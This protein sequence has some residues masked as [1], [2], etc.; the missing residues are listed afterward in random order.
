LYKANKENN[1]A[2][3]LYA[4]LTMICAL[5]GGIV[6]ISCLM[7]KGDHWTG[8]NKALLRYILVCCLTVSFL[9][10]AAKLIIRG[11]K[12]DNRL[13][14]IAGLS[15]VLVTLLASGY[16]LSYVSKMNDGWTQEKQN[17]VLNT[18]IKQ[19]D[20]KSLDIA[21]IMDIAR[22][23]LKTDDFIVQDKIYD[24][25]SSSFYDC[26]CFV[27]EVMHQFKND[28]EYH[29]ALEKKGGEDKFY[30]EM[31]TLCPC[32]SKSYTE[33]EVEVIDIDF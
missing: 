33:D 32:G 12:G 7:L 19:N 13:S 21:A 1:P 26:P 9:F 20:S 31:D 30:A 15:W 17:V 4:A 22:D 29:A 25:V 5:S 6:L 3:S 8:E 23:T 14:Q 16:A 10:L 27:K 11:R 18:C 28:L 24:I 2:L